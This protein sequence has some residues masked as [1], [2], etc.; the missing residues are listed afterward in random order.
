MIQPPHRFQ[1]QQHQ[2]HAAERVERAGYRAALK[3][4]VAAEQHVPHH[5]QRQRGQQPVP[6]PH[7]VAKAQRH[8][9]QQKHQK[10]HER[11]VDATQN[12]RG[13]DG[14]RRIQMKHRHRDSQ[15]RHESAQPA[16]QPVTRALLGLDEFFGL[17]QGLIADDGLRIT[18]HAHDKLIFVIALRK[19]PRLTSRAGFIGRL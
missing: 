11:H 15:N 7:L 14:H 3:E 6:P 8:R 19:K 4:R 1:N 2:D 5:I 9:K 17:F 18:G 12:V 16:A 13:H 10:Q